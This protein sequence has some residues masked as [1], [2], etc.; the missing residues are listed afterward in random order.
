MENYLLKMI[1]VLQ[2]FE[3]IA[4]CLVL[5]DAILNLVFLY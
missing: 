3:N 2:N 4:L 1:N 5:S